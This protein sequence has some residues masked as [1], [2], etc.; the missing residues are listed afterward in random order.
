LAMVELRRALKEKARMNDEWGTDLLALGYRQANGGNECKWGKTRVVRIR[1]P[2]WW[3]R[4]HERA[5]FGGEGGGD[6]T[7]SP[8]A[9]TAV[10]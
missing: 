10:F 6:R 4:R 9:R 8:V 5:W 7:H 2:W 1:R 3:S